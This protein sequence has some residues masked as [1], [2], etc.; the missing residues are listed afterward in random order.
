[1]ANVKTK[2]GER[3]TTSNK[4]GI[5]QDKKTVK[6]RQSSQGKITSAKEVTAN[7]VKGP[8]GKKGTNGSTTKK[9][10][11]VTSN[12]KRV[13]TKTTKLKKKPVTKRPS[14]RIAK[15]VPQENVPMSSGVS[16]I[17]KREDS[18]VSI[19]PK[20]STNGNK[21]VPIV[22]IKNYLLKFF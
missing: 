6:K 22:A 16:E 3:K 19:S 5:S 20:P 2:S 4:S 11:K 15:Q 12:K 7:V 1:M 8:R 14:K 10:M 9:S 13:T 17:K 21:V 18:T